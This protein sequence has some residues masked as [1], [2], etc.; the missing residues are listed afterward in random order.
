MIDVVEISKSVLNRLSNLNYELGGGNS[1]ER[2][3]FPKKIQGNG[4]KPIDRISEQELRQIFIEEF[5]KE[6]EN[7]YYSIETPTINKYR[8]RDSNESEEAKKQ[9]ALHDMCVFE[10]VGNDFT[11]KLNIE[12]KHGN[13]AIKNTFKDILKLVQENENGVFIHL[14]KN[15]KRDTL[16]NE[17][18]TG[19]FDKLYESFSTNNNNWNNVDKSIHLIIIS[20]KQKTLIH[21]EIK[22]GADLN[23]VFLFQ[24]KKGNIKEVNGNAWG[25]ETTF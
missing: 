5:K 17:S 7:L 25:I 14:L 22:K 3:I 16:S 20:L 9:S 18:K 24:G 23:D 11:R 13:G 15:T 6:H 21:R 10:K 2:L 1:E 12:F 19:V 4:T 8:F